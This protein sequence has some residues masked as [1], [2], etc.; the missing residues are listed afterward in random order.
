MPWNAL[1]ETLLQLVASVQAPP[2]SGITVTEALIE[3]PLE[4][5]GAV[6]S[7]ELVFFA[8][9]PHSRWKSGVLPEVHLGR[10]LIELVEEGSANG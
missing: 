8:T 9:P 5:Q 1:S 7:G 4:V 6:R 10:L 2:G 3:I